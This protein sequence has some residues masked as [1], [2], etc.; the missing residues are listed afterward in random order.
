MRGA[1]GPYSRLIEVQEH[2]ASHAESPD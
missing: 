2:D 1:D